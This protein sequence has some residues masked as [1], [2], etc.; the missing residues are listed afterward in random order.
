MDDAK[1]DE[2]LESLLHGAG[3]F[4][5]PQQEKIVNLA[6]KSKEHHDRLQQKL[7]T[8]QKS[9]DYLRLSIKY[10]IFDLEATRRENVDLRKRLNDAKPGTETDF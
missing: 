3:S 4:P 6:N 5:P 10:L 1:F 8:L 9:L 7:S 2:R